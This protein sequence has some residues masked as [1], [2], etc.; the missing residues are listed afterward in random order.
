[1]T[2]AAKELRRQYY[3]EYYRQHPEA[4]REANHRYWER[5]AEEAQQKQKDYEEKDVNKHDD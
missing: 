5:K 1:M 2:E 4:R 3:R